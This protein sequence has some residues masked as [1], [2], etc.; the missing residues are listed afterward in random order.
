M[1]T[2]RIKSDGQR[3]DGVGVPRINVPL[4]YVTHDSCRA[5]KGCYHTHTL[6]RKSHTLL[7][8]NH[9]CRIPVFV[10]ETYCLK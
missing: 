2:D 10:D 9:V 7:F 4:S 3:S 8:T 1:A 6:H 5:K